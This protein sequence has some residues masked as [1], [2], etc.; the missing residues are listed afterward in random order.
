MQDPALVITAVWKS[1]IGTRS[2]DQGE[3]VVLLVP[4]REVHEVSVINAC[5]TVNRKS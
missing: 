2:R 5:P 1:R 3:M 4:S